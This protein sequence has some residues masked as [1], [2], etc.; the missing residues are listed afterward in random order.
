MCVEENLSSQR[1]LSALPATAVT[2]DDLVLAAQAGDVCAVEELL[3]RHRPML[4]K[5][6]RKFTLNA[7]DAEDLVQNAM[8]LA[9][10]HIRSFRREAKFTSWLTTIINNCFRTQLRKN[11]R[12]QWVYIDEPSNT[13]E[14]TI[15]NV[16]LPDPRTNPEEDV[17]EN[18]LR[19]QLRIAIQRHPSKQREILKACVLNEVPLKQVAHEFGI[20]VAST[21]TQLH[22]AKR[23]LRA[24]WAAR[25][26]T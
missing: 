19:K 21:K 9:F 24:Y 7:Y 4:C 5:A 10:L 11:A 23:R 6:A 22:R 15:W 26:S 25:V 12:V 13:V 18:D 14:G 8:L 2:E 1:I 17:V 16:D 3:I 20:T